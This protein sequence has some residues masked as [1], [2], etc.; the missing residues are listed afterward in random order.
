VT[1]L[2]LMIA[3]SILTVIAGGI[4]AL[5]STGLDTYRIGMTTADVERRTVQVLE[6]I[7]DELANAGQE[8]VHPRPD[9][10]SA[11]SRVSLQHNVGFADGKIQWSAPTVI[12]L[13]ADPT[14]PDDGKDNNGN[15]LIDEKI[16]VRR[17]RAGTPTEETQVLTRWVREYLE[18]EIPNG[19][20]DNGN[21]LVDEPGLSFDVIGQVWT[22]RLTLERHDT[23]GRLVTHTVQTAV[24][25]R[26]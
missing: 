8:V 19:K 5:F 14:D 13:R 7:A 6:S 17:I 11:S 1:L 9:H 12:A 26:N 16:I 25:L 24:K 2:E 4:Y 23:K 15:G 18:G 10:P 21:G 22:V 3:T 20:D